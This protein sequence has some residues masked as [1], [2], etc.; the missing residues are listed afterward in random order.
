MLRGTPRLVK[1]KPGRQMA[2]SGW[3]GLRDNGAYRVTA[4]TEIPL[5]ATL[6]SLGVLLLAVSAMWYREGR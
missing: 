4:V 1:V 3:I 2:G 5:F 6:L